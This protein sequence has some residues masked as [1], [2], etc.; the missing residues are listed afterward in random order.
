LFIRRRV[1]TEGFAAEEAGTTAYFCA[2]YENRKG[3]EGK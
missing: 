3:D 1:E 2:R